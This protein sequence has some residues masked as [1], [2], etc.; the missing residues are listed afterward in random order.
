MQNH[1]TEGNYQHSKEDHE[2]VEQI[3]RLPQKA[4]S[5]LY[6]LVKFLDTPLLGELIAPE[7]SLDRLYELYVIWREEAL[8]ELQTITLV[9]I[10]RMDE[11]VRSE[12][13]DEAVKNLGIC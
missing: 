7:T 9:R 11:D 3:S 5:S 13:I 4:I 8:I 10:I 6:S 1:N 12:K 2:L